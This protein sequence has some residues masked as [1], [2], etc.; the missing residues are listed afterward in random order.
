MAVGA[1]VADNGI[2]VEKLFTFGATSVVLIAAVIANVNAITVGVDSERNFIGEKIF[3]ALVA[4]QVL[5]VK[6]VRANVGAVMNNGHLSLVEIFFAVLAEAIILVQAVVADVNTFA[7]A[8]NDFPS[9]GTIIFTFLAELATVVV[10]IVTEKFGRNFISAGNAKSVGAYIENLVVLLMVSANR[11]FSVEVRVTPVRITAETIA[12][13][14]MDAM[15]IAAVF[16]GLP[17]VRNALKL[18]NFTLNQIA[19][20]L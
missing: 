8:I 14:N 4:K 3:V 13:S 12:A 7:V 17:E 5:L 9:F 10:A 1:K 19:I 20:K 18:G 2:V 16:F 11:N 15:F 6:T